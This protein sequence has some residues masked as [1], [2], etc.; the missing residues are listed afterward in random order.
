MT[1][2]LLKILYSANHKFSLKDKVCLLGSIF[3]NTFFSTH[4]P[5]GYLLGITGQRKEK[6]I[7][8]YNHAFTQGTTHPTPLGCYPLEARPPF[9]DHIFTPEIVKFGLRNNELGF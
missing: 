6:R 1:K 2:K 7:Y 8:I 3:F 5:C 9:S 4:I